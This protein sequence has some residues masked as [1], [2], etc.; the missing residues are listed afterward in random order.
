MNPEDNQQPEDNQL[1]EAIRLGDKAYTQE[2]LQSL[3]GLGEQARDLEGKWN[4]KI[5]RLMPE[6]TKTRQEMADLRR[7]QDEAQRRDL[8]QKQQQGN[9]NP[10]EQ[11]R[12]IVG[13]L[14]GYMADPEISGY[15]N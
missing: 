14:K 4:T 6:Y 3:V 12:L 10:D 7:Q 2:E 15:I 5:D 11:R 1:P 8:T 13:E 9:L